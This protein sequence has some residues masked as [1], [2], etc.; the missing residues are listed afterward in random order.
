MWISKK[1]YQKLLERITRAECGVEYTQKGIQYL[2]ERWREHESRITDL[3]REV[4]PP[5][6]KKYLHG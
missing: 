1:N 4:F 3:E 5:S 6:K 2:E